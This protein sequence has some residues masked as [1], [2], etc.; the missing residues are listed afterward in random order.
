M[1]QMPYYPPGYQAPSPYASSHLMQPDNGMPQLPPPHV[2]EPNTPSPGAA[3]PAKRKQVKNACTNC[4]K[5]CK[6]CDEA[7]P[8]PRCVKYGITETC[9]NSTRKERKKGVK[10]GPYKRRQKGE[11]GDVSTPE[12][13]TPRRKNSPEQAPQ[14]DPQNIRGSLPFAYGNGLNQYGQPY[15]AY[16][17]YASQ[18]Y[19]V[20]PVYPGMPYQVPQIVPGADGHG[21][22]QQG[23]HAQYATHSPLPHSQQHS[24]YNG[25]Q[26]SPH[27]QSRSLQQQMHSDIKDEQK[28]HQPLTPVPS[29]SNSS[30]ASSPHV[31]VASQGANASNPGENDEERSRLARLSQLCQA[32]L[33]QSDGPNATE[34]T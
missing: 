18:Q 2:S 13:R 5:A 8:C 32:A 17:Q 28:P 16:G 30:A 11:D 27:Q 23:Q 10:R 29:T 20:N 6:K 4:Q 33:D 19:M 14:Y 15:D 3:H 7:R 34:S 26:G 21:Q 9:V 1:Q 24:P 25:Y 31:N 22:G 12:A